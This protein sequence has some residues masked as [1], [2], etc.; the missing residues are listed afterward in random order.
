VT[1]RSAV[2]SHLA[3]RDVARVIYGAIVGLALVVA[4]ERH[5]PTAGQTAGSLVATAVA[6]GLAEVYSE[7]VAAETRTRRP[8]P[9]G[10]VL[11]YAAEAAAVVAGAGFPAV[12]FLLSLAGAIDLDTAFALAKW[13][14]LGLIGGYGFL[15]ARLAGAHAVRAAAHGVAVAAVGLALIALKAVLH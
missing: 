14:G 13:S 5:P 12:F 8:V 3:S 4:L 11:G 9:R 7:V 10:D 2:E 6:V 1:L 15:A